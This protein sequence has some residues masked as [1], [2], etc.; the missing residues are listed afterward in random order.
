MELGELK[1]QLNYHIG[2]IEALKNNAKAIE[3]VN[4]KLS[5]FFTG[6]SSKNIILNVNDDTDISALFNELNKIGFLKAKKLGRKYKQY[7]IKVTRKRRRGDV[8]MAEVK[9]VQHE[10]MVGLERA[11]EG[12]LPMLKSTLEK[13]EEV[14]RSSDTIAF[15]QY[16]T[17]VEESA[18]RFFQRINVLGMAVFGE[19][20]PEP[21]CTFKTNSEKDPEGLVGEFAVDDKGGYV[22]IFY[23][24][25]LFDKYKLHR[26]GHKS[27]FE[28]DIAH[29]LS[30]IFDAK[31]FGP[32][33]NTQ[34]MNE[35]ARVKMLRES[36]AELIGNYVL[37]Q[38]AGSVNPERD[39]ALAVLS[40]TATTARYCS[41]SVKG[42][43]AAAEKALQA[44]SPKLVATT[45]RME[46][47]LDATSPGLFVQDM[48]YFTPQIAIC[49][50]LLETGMPMADFVK[51]VLNDPLQ[52]NAL[53][54]ALGKE[55]KEL[56]ESYVDRYTQ[57]RS[58]AFDEEYRAAKKARDR[59]ARSWSN[60]ITTLAT[61]AI[62]NMREPPKVDLDAVGV[63]ADLR[64]T[65][66]KS[67]LIV[68][69]ES[70]LAADAE[71]LLQKYSGRT[72]S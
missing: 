63:R 9:T 34:G 44:N 62:G 19:D 30:H 58:Q 66:K 40:K 13:R 47:L 26:D 20:L 1:E 55:K 15:Q 23:D 69:R 64:A 42:Y 49:K 21:R 3:S 31:V 10:G 45:T 29:E 36:L 72:A 7:K 56:I 50:A 33:S 59:D 46:R 4:S 51:A 2:T 39:A 57:A 48:M 60:F 27:T 43:L 70:E 17:A 71:L 18:H 28:R 65:M 8:V 25:H 53:R 68:E 11:S 37:K 32:S 6:I 22:V 52:F 54:E 61:A 67:E 14:L 35:L 41:D 12:T 38:E 24:A 5:A 16:R